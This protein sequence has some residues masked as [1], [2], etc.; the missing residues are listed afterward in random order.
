[1]GLPA[2]NEEG[3]K[4]SSPLFKAGNLGKTKLM[5]MHNLEDDN[6]HF[7]NS[8]QMAD[9]LELAGQ[10]FSMVIYPQKTHH[11]AGPAYKQ[12]LDQIASFFE[13]NLK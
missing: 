1:M 2:E 12:L 6:V 8:M 4:A 11:V 7:Q 13:E 3:Y 9:A 5:I 10:Q